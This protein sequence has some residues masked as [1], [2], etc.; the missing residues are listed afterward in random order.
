MT[1]VEMLKEKTGRD[2]EEVTTTKTN[3]LKLEGVRVID[4][5]VNIL[6]IMY[7]PKNL[8]DE[9]FANYVAENYSKYEQSSN[10]DIENILTKEYVLNN[11]F[12]ALI[13]T[14]MNEEI[15][16]ETVHK[17]FNDLSIIYKIDISKESSVITL[18]SSMLDYLKVTEDEIHEAAIKNIKPKLTD[19]ADIMGTPSGMMYVLS[20]VQ[21]LYGAGVILSNDVLDSLYEDIGSFY[22]IPS[23]L[24]EVICLPK[25]TDNTEA[26]KEMVMSINRAE[27]RLEERLSDNVYIYNGNSVELVGV[28]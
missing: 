7:R 4:D 17:D 10:F 25:I 8:S 6:P 3:G 27:L 20:N 1:L 5:T 28:A 23:S 11:V 21:Y 15:L 18:K 12:P 24:H 19:M 9:Q 14:A 2:F 22:I 13:N 26:L 16:S